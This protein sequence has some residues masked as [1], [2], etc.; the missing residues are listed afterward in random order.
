MSD[1]RDI[2]ITHHDP[3]MHRQMEEAA[4]SVREWQRSNVAVGGVCDFCGTPF[5][6]A[7]GIE[8]AVTWKGGAFSSSLSALDLDTL[9]TASL[10][11]LQNPYWMACPGCDAEVAKRDAAALADYV[12]ANRH[13]RVGPVVAEILAVVRDDLVG[14]YAA[15]FATDPQ[16]WTGEEPKDA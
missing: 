12:I 14:M 15:F 9:G 13:E 5:S 7:G 8:A 16:R 6:E 3:A 10:D 4:E 2:R 11:I 1:R